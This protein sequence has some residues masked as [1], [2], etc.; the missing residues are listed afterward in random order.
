MPRTH[1]G[2][3]HPGAHRR[4]IPH[5]PGRVHP[6][7]RR[8]RTH[9]DDGTM[10]GRVR[11]RVAAAAAP[12]LPDLGQRPRW[13]SLD[14]PARLARDQRLSRRLRRCPRFRG[15]DPRDDGTLSCGSVEVAGAVMMA[16][17]ASTLAVYTDATTRAGAEAALRSLVV[18]LAPHLDIVVCGPHPGVIEPIA[19]A[20]PGARPLV[21]PR[22]ATRADLTER[23]PGSVGADRHRRLGPTAQ[24]DRGGRTPLRRSRRSYHSR[25]ADRFGGPRRRRS[26]FARRTPPQQ[27]AGENRR[28][29]D[30]RRRSRGPRTRTHPRARAGF[31]RRD[32]Q[33]AVARAVRRS[34]HGCVLHRRDAR[35]P[36]PPQAC[37]PARARGRRA[38]RGASRHRRGGTRGTCPAAAL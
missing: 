29:G 31:G 3:P 9:V 19:A 2:P 15:S 16:R 1:S 37:R 20:R 22:L 6:V 23:D 27:D 14:S 33:R 21:V 28:T 35:P 38:P 30:R 25:A 26:G 32:P 8:R 5:R 7:P 4:R 12:A 24:Q 18:H 11:H 36:R 10:G 17:Q 13:Q 34:S